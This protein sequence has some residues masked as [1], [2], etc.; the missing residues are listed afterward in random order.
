MQD[1][2]KDTALPVEAYLISRT[3]LRRYVVTRVDPGET[4]EGLLESLTCSSHQ[5][6][7][8]RYIGSAYTCLVTL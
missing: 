5:V 3:D 7:S 8:T 2:L 4:P 1:I 6:T